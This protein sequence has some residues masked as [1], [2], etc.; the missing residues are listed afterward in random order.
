MKAPVLGLLT[1]SLALAGS[2]LYLWQQLRVERERSAQ[3]QET[4]RQLEARLPISPK[5]WD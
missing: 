3:V 4:T 2:S 5:S 1:A